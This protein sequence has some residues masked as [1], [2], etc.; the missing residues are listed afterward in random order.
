MKIWNLVAASLAATL[1]VT[2]S[3]SATTITFTEVPGLFSGQTVTNQWAPFGI[4]ID[5]GYWY[6]DGRDPFDQTGIANSA[7]FGQISFLSSTNSFTVDW[8]TISSSITVEAFNSSNVLLD[9]F[10]SRCVNGDTCSG[11]NTL[12]GSNIA[13]FTFRDSGGTVGISTVT[14][15]VPEPGTLAILGLGLAG[16]AATRRRK[17]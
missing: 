10:S 8:L 14:F 15:G 4:N 11:T 5:S 3:A 9:S 12:N 7:A 16:L 2:S 13:Y 17:Q 1:A 6:V